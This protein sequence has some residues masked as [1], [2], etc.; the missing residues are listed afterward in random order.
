M[1]PTINAAWFEQWLALPEHDRTAFASWHRAE[2]D[3]VIEERGGVR[4]DPAEWDE[5]D[6]IVAWEGRYQG[7]VDLAGKWIKRVE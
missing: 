7:V 3:R 6:A 4:S 5:Y 1:R 2:I